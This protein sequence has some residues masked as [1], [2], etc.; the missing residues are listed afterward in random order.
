MKK[1]KVISCV[2]TVAVMS[3]IFFFSSQPAEVSSETSSG[4]AE[5]VIKFILA[6][7]CNGNSDLNLDIVH[8]IVRK[9]AHFS[10]YLILALS[11]GNAVYQLFGIRNIR[12]FLYTLSFCLIYAISDEIHQMFV[13]GRTA[14]VMDVGIDFMGAVCGCIIY[15]WIK[16]ICDR[17][18]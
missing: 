4:I 16:R 17:R 13:P 18:K 8:K 9:L 12:L 5:K 11:A 2:A 14:M 10:L 7:F 3:T 15:V 1:I 6:V